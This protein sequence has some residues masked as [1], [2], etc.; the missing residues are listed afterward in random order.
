MDFRLSVIKLIWM[1][2]F[3]A[4]FY[5]HLV[6]DSVV[7]ARMIWEYSIRVIKAFDGKFKSQQCIMSLD[8]AILA[9][10]PSGA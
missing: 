3:C 6:N 1:F 9:I 7:L 10:A 2:Q 5:T 4:M 8:R